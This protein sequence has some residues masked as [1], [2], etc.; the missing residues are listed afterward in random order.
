MASDSFPKKQGKI[1]RQYCISFQGIIW[2]FSICKKESMY[3]LFFQGGKYL[4]FNNIDGKVLGNFPRDK[5]HYNIQEEVGA[6]V[7]FPGGRSYLVEG[8][9]LWR[10]Y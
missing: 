2:G 4:R 5:R 6:L 10:S 8:P 9:I 7:N 3:K 1:S